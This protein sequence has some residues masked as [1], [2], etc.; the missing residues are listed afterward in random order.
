MHGPCLAFLRLGASGLPSGLISS[1]ER[2][3]AAV[4]SSPDSSH[5]GPVKDISGMRVS[6][7]SLLS[8]AI[9]KHD[10]VISAREGKSSKMGLRDN[11][12]GDLIPQVAAAPVLGSSRI[13]RLNKD[14]VPSQCSS[15]R[16]FETAIHKL[17]VIAAHAENVTLCGNA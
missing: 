17:R 5:L 13:A 4:L 12:C 11:P 6:S 3:C 7:F 14:T 2:T 15:R 8:E 16:N 10:A 9:F 1:N